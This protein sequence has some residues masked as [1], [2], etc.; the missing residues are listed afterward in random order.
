MTTTA[1][2]YPSHFLLGIG[3]YRQRHAKD[4]GRLIENE[5]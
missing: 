4:E 5:Y 2:S 1:V 3:C